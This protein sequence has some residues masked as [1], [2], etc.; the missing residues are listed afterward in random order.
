MNHP[1]TGDP[2]IAKSFGNSPSFEQVDLFPEIA[3]DPVLSDIDRLI[4]SIPEP[5]TWPESEWL[6]LISHFI[7]AMWD[8]VIA[9]FKTRLDVEDKNKIKKNKIKKNG[10]KDK[11]LLELETEFLT[12]YIHTLDW[13]MGNH[14]GSIPLTLV[15][16]Y[17]NKVHIDH[18]LELSVHVILKLLRTHPVLRNDCFDL[19]VYKKGGKFF[20]DTPIGESDG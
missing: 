18:D 17:E 13:L 8:D 6:N 9:L 20:T 19:E 16:A 12:H 14:I 11:P 3:I 4:K 7:D 1:P 10:N 5:H 2:H 15:L